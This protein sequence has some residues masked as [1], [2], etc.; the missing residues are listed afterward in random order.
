MSEGVPADGGYLV[1]QQVAAGIIERMYNTGQVL[2]R[3]SVDPVTGN[4][5]LYNA[6]DETSRANGSRYGGLTSYWGAE[7]GTLTASKPKFRQMEEKLKKV[8]VLCYATDEQLEDT[9]NLASWLGRTVPEELRFKVE[10]AI[11]NGTGAGQPLGIMT[12]PCLVSVLRVDASEIDATD[13]A[14]MW[15]RRWAGARD[16]AWYLDQSTFPQLINLTV[17]NFPLMQTIGGYQNVPYNSIFGAPVIETEYNAA[18]GTTGDIMLAS[19]SQYQAITKGGV[20]ASS[21]IHVQFVT[22]EVAFKWT[23]RFDGQPAWQSALTPKNGG[24]TQSPFVV[25]S[26]ATV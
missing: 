21:S 20:K 9:A 22:D 24:S 2:S 6:V 10:D 13:I 25:L 1:P 12:A 8:H 17:G 18:L 3:I 7:A 23:Y 14:N 15:A 5:M 26:S 16:Y 11:F 19:M 4:S